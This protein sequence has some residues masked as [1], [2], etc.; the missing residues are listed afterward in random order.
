MDV[1]AL[2]HLNRTP[3]DLQQLGAAKEM[4]QQSNSAMMKGFELIADK[5]SKQPQGMT[6][7]AIEAM[8]AKQLAER[9]EYWKAQLET[10]APPKEVERARVPD[11]K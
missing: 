6:P 10:M 1:L 4:T 5:F 8:I 7:E 9:D 11:E 3:I 2:A